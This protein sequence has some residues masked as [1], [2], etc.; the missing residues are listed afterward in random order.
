MPAATLTSK[1]QLVVPKSI[2][3]LMG[4]HPGDRLDFVVLDDGNVLMR[5]ATEDVTR[6]KG[7]LQRTGRVPVSVDAMNRIIRKRG[8]RG[9]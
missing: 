4:L 6:L 1:G 3:D 9:R 2:R 8:A 7:L 5:P